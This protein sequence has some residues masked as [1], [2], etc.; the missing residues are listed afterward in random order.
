MSSKKKSLAIKKLP[1][2]KKMNLHSDRFVDKLFALYYGVVNNKSKSSA[3][4]GG[5]EF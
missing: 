3:V 1:K 4:R 5:Y 2:N